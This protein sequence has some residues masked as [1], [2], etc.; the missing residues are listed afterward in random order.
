M[1]QKL[2]EVQQEI[3]RICNEISDF[4]KEKN[5]KYGNSA[6]EPF[7]VFSKVDPIEKINVRIDDKL[8][9]IKNRQNDED[10]DVEWDLIGY[11]ILKRVALNLKKEDRKRWE[12]R[13][14]AKNGGTCVNHNNG[15]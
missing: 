2:M 5:R 11:L 12:I 15:I 10:E 6:F 9:R 4:L 14:E 1:K 13:E 3:E 8:A 7:N